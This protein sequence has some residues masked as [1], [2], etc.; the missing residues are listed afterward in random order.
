MDWQ[1]GAIFDADDYTDFGWVWLGTQPPFQSD[2]VFEA[3][4]VG[5]PTR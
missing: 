3:G 4:C 1:T 5:N 2:S